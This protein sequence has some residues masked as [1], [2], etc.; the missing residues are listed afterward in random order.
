MA[1]V[2][3]H[4]DQGLRRIDLR[5]RRPDGVREGD[6]VVEGAAGIAGVVAVIDPAGFDHQEE[7]V[8]IP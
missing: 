6:S 8:P 7:A 2:G 5:E 4:D 1:V 3:G